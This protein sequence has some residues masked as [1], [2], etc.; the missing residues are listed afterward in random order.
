MI[1]TCR[2]IHRTSASSVFLSA[3]A[4][5]WGSHTV[6]PFTQS[7]RVCERIRLCTFVR[8]F[9]DLQIYCTR[10]RRLSLGTHHTGSSPGRMVVRFSTPPTL[11]ST[12][13]RAL[14]TPY[15]FK[16]M[17]LTFTDVTSTTSFFS[18]AC[19]HTHTHTHMYP[20]RV[21]QHVQFP[22]IR[23]TLPPL[24]PF[25]SLHTHTHTHAPNTFLASAP[26]H[27]SPFT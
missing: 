16:S 21:V 1:G 5:T 6:S 15:A 18:S 12:W 3:L 24:P 4:N 20:H 13:Q 7:R 2:R 8:D 23:L 17:R 26:T 14:L 10:V 25:F 19:T 11:R 27:A 9:T 22:H